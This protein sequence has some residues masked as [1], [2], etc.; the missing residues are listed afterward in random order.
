MAPERLKWSGRLK[1]SC[2]DGSGRKRDGYMY[3]IQGTYTM[4]FN[5]FATLS[6]FG[7]FLFLMARKPVLSPVS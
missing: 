7:G 2:F 6:F 4:V 5:V 1:V 3:D